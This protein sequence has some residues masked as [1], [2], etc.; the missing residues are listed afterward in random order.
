[1][2][3]PL[4]DFIDEKL[5]LTEDK[6]TYEYVGICPQTGIKLTLSRTVLAEKVALSLANQLRDL[7]E[8]KIPLK[9]KSLPFQAVGEIENGILLNCKSLTQQDFNS[10]KGKMLGVLIVKDNQEQL[11]V[12]KAFSGFLAGKREVEGWVPPIPGYSV[13]A[14]AEK[15]TLAQL[16]EIK[17]EIIELQQLPIPQQ[18]QQLVTESE[19]QRQELKQLH[20]TRKQERDKQRKELKQTF[21]GESLNSKLHQLEQESRRDDWE[22]R[23]LKRQWQEKLTPLSTIIQ[24]SDHKIRE[25]K[26][27]R[28][29]LS[30]QLQAQMQTAFTLTNFAGNSLSVADVM[31][32]AFIPTGTGDCCAPKLLHYA[33]TNNLQPIAMAELWWGEST[34]NG[35][36]IAGKFYPACVERCQPLMGF[37][38]SGLPTLHHPSINQVIEILYEDEY[39]LIVNKPSGLLSVPGRGSDKFDSVVTL[40]QHQNTQLTNLKAVH[41]LDQDTSGIL[42]LTKDDSSYVNIS[43]QFQQRQVN[44]IYEAVLAGILTESEG[45]INLPLFGN[46]ENRPL[47]EVNWEKGKPS[48]THFRRLNISNEETRIEFKPITGRTHQLRVHSAD[49]QGLGIPI[50]GDRLYGKVQNNSSRLHLHAREIGFEHPQ[51]RQI[52]KLSTVTPF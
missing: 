25:L 49:N 17:Q 3:Q 34:P 20:Q 33:A 41:R 14:L 27:K 16:D 22:R 21:S 8:N 11:G 43:W 47:Q 46:P 13:I 31:G 12:I 42:I 39:L 26:Q 5:L 28:K 32:K 45:V 18:Y 10:N 40:L 1:M 36:K 23:K 24:Q 15:L 38:L 2:L 44:K 51:T 6:I 30:R 7:R 35:E 29:Q 9:K 48:I 52:I 37:L 4:T 50:K 19:N